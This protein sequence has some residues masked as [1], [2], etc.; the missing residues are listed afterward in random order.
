MV[1]HGF[2]HTFHELIKALN[3]QKTCVTPIITKSN[4]ASSTVAS[5]NESFL[6]TKLAR[7]IGL[8]CS[9]LFASERHIHRPRPSERGAVVAACHRVAVAGRITPNLGRMVRATPT[10][11][12]FIIVSKQAIQR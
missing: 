2:V 11:I 4:L 12:K 7:N 8:A 6:Y 10:T 5:I 1:D 3:Y 9:V